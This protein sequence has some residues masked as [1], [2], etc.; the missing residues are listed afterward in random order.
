MNQVQCSRNQPL[1]ETVATL[2]ASV[3][4]LACACFLFRGGRPPSGVSARPWQRSQSIR[5]AR[6]SQEACFS[7]GTV[8]AWAWRALLG[9]AVPATAASG[10]SPPSTSPNRAV[11]PETGS[12][13]CPASPVKLLL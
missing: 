2:P 10:S 8:Q 4:A 11:T 13:H 12:S 7:P 9:A 3:I 6:G 1:G 5:G